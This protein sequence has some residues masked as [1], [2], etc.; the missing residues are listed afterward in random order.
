MGRQA[1][2]VEH[3]NPEGLSRNPAFS[4]VIVVSGNAKTVYVGGQDSVD[5]EGNVVG[6]GDIG[7]QSEQVM[8]NVQTALAAAGADLGDVV[9]WTVLIVAGQPLGP[10]FAA[11]QKA[12][13]DR[14]N[15]PTVTAAFVSALAHPDFLVEIDAIAVIPG[16]G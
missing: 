8:G 15:P 3:L 1:G 13:G 7:A 2:R 16:T 5:A 9:R 6:V 4:N 11:F 14:P 12:W 10:G